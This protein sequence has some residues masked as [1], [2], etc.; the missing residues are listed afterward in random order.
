MIE[1]APKLTEQDLLRYYTNKGYSNDTDVNVVIDKV[2]ENYEYWDTVKYKKRPDNCSAEELWK[3][4]KMSRIL[5]MVNTWDK[6]KID[7][8]FT[9]K[10]QRL[11]HEF[12]MNFGQGWMY[13]PDITEDNKKQYLRSSLMEEAIYSSMIEGAATTRKVAK[14]MLRLKKQ[15][16]DKS[17]QMIVNNYNTIQFISSHKDTPLS[18]ELLLQIHRLITEKTLKNEE[19]AGRFRYDEDDIVVFD[20]MA[21]ETVHTPPAAAALPHFANDLC[22]YFNDKDAKPY[23]HPIIRGIIIHFMVGYFHPFVDGNGRTARAL[24]YW[25]M[26]KEGYWMTEY[27]SISRVI[28]KSKTSYEKA[29]LYTEADDMDLGYF[30]NYNLKVLEQ[31]YRELKEYIQRKQAEKKASYQFMRL[32]YINDRQAQVIQRFVDDPSE[33]ITVKDLQE[34]FFI[35]PTTA[36]QDI[37]HLMER[38]LLKE[39]AFNKVKKGYIKGEKFDEILAT[40]S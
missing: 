30:I 36:K 33:I 16:K 1:K 7:F 24:F 23:V 21:G 4:V 39:I 28:A 27:L 29:Y 13:Q 17:Q 32:G 9:N 8:G 10:M 11:C 35:S 2:N 18:V 34:R 40:I 37:V 14:E 31:A 19:D 5:M 20:V 3:R 26:L 6:Y 12:D 38:G 22:K 15:P 25:Y